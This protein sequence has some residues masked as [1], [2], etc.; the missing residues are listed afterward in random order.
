MTIRRL[1]TGQSEAASTAAAIAGTAGRT[2]KAEAAHRRGTDREQSTVCEPGEL[3]R[4]C[5]RTIR[6]ERP[7]PGQA[8][9]S[10]RA[11]ETQTT[12][13]VKRQSEGSP[14]PVA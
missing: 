7:L 6:C 8:I 10:I 4:N 12:Q 11:G 14:R 2:E 1:R 5:I 3:H 13:T 9:E